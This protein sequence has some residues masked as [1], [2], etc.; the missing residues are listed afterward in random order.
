MFFNGDAQK[1]EILISRLFWSISCIIFRSFGAQL[2]KA[3][4]LLRVCEPLRMLLC[5]LCWYELLLATQLLCQVLSARAWLLLRLWGSIDGFT[6][7]YL[8]IVYRYTYV[9]VS[10]HTYTY[11]APYVH[12]YFPCI[13]A[14]Q[15][16]PFA[17]C[18]WNI[19][20]RG[21]R[22]LRTPPHFCLSKV[23]ATILN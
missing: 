7:M 22:V 13:F 6:H 17:R 5:L 4:S 12:S 8:H 1:S 2:R 9:F 19:F 16:F 23:S 20:Y 21:R 18:A 11:I 10:R 14:S 3:T 15:I